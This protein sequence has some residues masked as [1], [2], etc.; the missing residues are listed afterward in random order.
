M[1]VSLGFVDI[2]DF[3]KPLFYKSKN[4]LTISKDMKAREI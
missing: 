1:T 3:K 2:K 4:A